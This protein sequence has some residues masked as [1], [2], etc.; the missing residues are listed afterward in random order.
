MF[1][2]GNGV[3]GGHR[4]TVG[5]RCQYNDRQG[6][7][8]AFTRAERVQARSAMGNFPGL[9]AMPPACRLIVDVGK[10]C[11]QG[12]QD[13]AMPYGKIGVKLHPGALEPLR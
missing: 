11:A 3:A 5:L 9:V 10:F 12:A 2:N 13:N 4:Q 8:V 6:S 7:R 1:E